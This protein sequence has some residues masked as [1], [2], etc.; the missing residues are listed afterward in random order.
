MPTISIDLRSVSSP[1]PVT[2]ASASSA[3]HANANANAN[4]ALDSKARLNSPSYRSDTFR[5]LVVEQS[6][7]LVIYSAKCLTIALG[8]YDPKVAYDVLSFRLL[9]SVDSGNN[10]Y[11]SSF[12]L[13]YRII[14]HRTFS[15]VQVTSL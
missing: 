10:N 5:K 7:T 15:F 14:E 12:N 3:F 11:N 13:K 8:T 1:V 6:S 4:L 9:E 2:I